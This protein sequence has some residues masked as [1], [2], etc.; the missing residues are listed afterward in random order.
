M[1]VSRMPRKPSPSVLW[2]WIRRHTSLPSG[3]KDRPHIHRVQ[4]TLFHGKQPR[5]GVFPF[6]DPRP[7][8]GRREVRFREDRRCPHQAHKGKTGRSGGNGSE[9]Q[10]N[11]LQGRGTGSVKE[12]MPSLFRSIVRGY[13]WIILLLAVIAPLI[14]FSSLRSASGKGPPRTHPF[15]Q[16]P[17]A[18]G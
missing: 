15:R 5:K 6:K 13:L 8:L 4:N 3:Q 9:C 7:P 16:G 1:T 12:R 14:V 17:C 18:N 11:R 10:G 2:K